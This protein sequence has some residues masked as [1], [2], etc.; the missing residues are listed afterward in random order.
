MNEYFFFK[1]KMRHRFG[2]KGLRGALL[3]GTRGIKIGKGTFFGKNCRLECYSQYMNF[4]YNA[5]ICIGKDNVFMGDDT[6]LSAGILIIGDNCLF[7]K[8]V[9]IT[10]ENHGINIEP[11]SSF[12]FQ[13]LAVKNVLIGNNCWIGEK[14][15]ILPG[16][17]LGNNCVVGAG[18]IVTKSFPDSCI[19]A[20]NP[21]KIIKKWDGKKWV[22]ND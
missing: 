6:L 8:E 18:A 1:I 20:G 5:S 11:G 2:V 14:A 21:A 4:Q 17:S 15:I 12:V 13:P 9:F 22:K 10:N 16:V 7:A 3:F 19:I